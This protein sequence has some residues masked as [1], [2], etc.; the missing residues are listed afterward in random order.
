MISL[1]LFTTIRAS[2]ALPWRL[3]WKRKTATK[4]GVATLIQK[5]WRAV[6]SGMLG[7][8]TA[9]GPRGSKL[10]LPYPHFGGNAALQNSATSC[11]T[12]ADAACAAC[13]PPSG[14]SVSAACE[15]S[16]SRTPST[17]FV[18]V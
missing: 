12:R 1:S 11:S 13:T 9:C 2:S 6:L 16:N 15:A 17:R 5:L 10:Q 4:F 14:S 8:P 7:T 18:V 3:G